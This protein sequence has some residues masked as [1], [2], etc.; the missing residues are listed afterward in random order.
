[1]KIR[2]TCFVIPYWDDGLRPP[3][4]HWYKKGIWKKL[5]RNKFIRKRIVEDDKAE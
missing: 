5:L 4:R 3:Y 2:N 1:M